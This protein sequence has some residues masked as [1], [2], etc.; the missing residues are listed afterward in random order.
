ML[1]VSGSI[2]VTCGQC[3]ANHNISAEDADFENVESSERQ[4]GAEIG[5]RWEH[6][7]ECGCGN[8]IE[9][10]YDVWEYSGGTFNSD[11]IIVNGGTHQGSFEYDFSQ[12]N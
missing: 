4:M 3:G 1:I 8:V 11:S 7:I 10:E 9:V 2:D 5:H 12:G 6:E